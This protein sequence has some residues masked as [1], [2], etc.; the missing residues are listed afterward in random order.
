MPSDIPIFRYF[1][2]VGIEKT[3]KFKRKKFQDLEEK[4]EIERSRK[5]ANVEPE[6]M[7]REENHDEIAKKVGFKRK[8][9]CVLYIV[10]KNNEKPF[11]IFL[12]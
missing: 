12:K 8:L 9:H 5:E 11:A 10:K 4:I 1:R 6:S 3:N 7:G 2:L